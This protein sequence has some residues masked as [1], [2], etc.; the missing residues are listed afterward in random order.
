MTTGIYTI[1]NKNNN[2]RYIGS[3]NNIEKRLKY[4]KS[5]LKN[6]KKIKDFTYLEVKE[7]SRE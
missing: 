5:L 7:K 4:H 2:K 3:S 6:N 1:I